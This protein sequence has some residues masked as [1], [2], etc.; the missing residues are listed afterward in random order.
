MNSQN[1]VPRRMLSYGALI[2]GTVIGS[3]A[4]GIQFA[5]YVNSHFF[6]EFH[7]Q[8]S[9]TLILFYSPLDNM[10]EQASTT[11]L[12]VAWFFSLFCLWAVLL[13]NYFHPSRSLLSD[14]R[15]VPRS[16]RRRLLL[17]FPVGKTGWSFVVL[18]SPLILC[19]P[20]EGRYGETSEAPFIS[21]ALVLAEVSAVLSTK[22]S[23]ASQNWDTFARAS[24]L[25]SIAFILLIPFSAYLMCLSVIFFPVNCVLLLTIRDAIRA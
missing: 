19:W 21:L 8:I 4:A 9:R 11:N 13:S 22:I 12:L 10:N 16:A 3:L 6:W 17:L 15:L 7:G 5:F 2:A 20:I 14:L 1:L 18:F 23:I 25:F 24:L